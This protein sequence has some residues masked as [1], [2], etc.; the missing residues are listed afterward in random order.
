MTDV[1]T[2]HLT[3][4]ELLYGDFDD[5]F[6]GTR[7]MLERYPEEHRD[8]RPHGKSRTLGE[9]ATH[10]SDLPN[11]GTVVLQTQGM[12]LATRRPR[13]PFASRQE[14]LAHFEDSVTSFR[15]ALGST[16]L[17]TLAEPWTIRN[18]DRVLLAQPRRVLVRRMMMNHLTHHRAQLTVYY[19]LLGVPVPGMYGPS[20]DEA[21]RP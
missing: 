11:R 3:V 10:V 15:A 5:E 12:D 6:A 2:D 20:A 17:T 21:P 19:R 7:R 13:A 16:D 4:A 18:G 14:L 8:W 1:A 9:L